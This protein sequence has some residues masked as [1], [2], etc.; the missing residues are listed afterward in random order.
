MTT[1]DEP[2]LRNTAAP[3]PAKPA[4]DLRMGEAGERKLMDVKTLKVRANPRKSYS[5]ESIEELAR[6]IAEVGQIQD[7]LV[8]LDTDGVPELIV[9]SRRKR[10]IEW[11]SEKYPN[12]PEFSKIA[13]VVRK[14]PEEAIPAIQFIENEDR[15]ALTAVEVAD[16]IMVLKTTLGW[17]DDTIAEKL[18][19]GQKKIVS[20]YL[21]IA[22]APPWLKLYAVPSEHE[23]TKLD[24]QGQPVRNADGKKQ[25]TTV[26]GVALGMTHLFELA[27]FH[28][29]IEKWDKKSKSANA[30]HV[31]QAHTATARNAKKAALEDWSKA[32][33]KA[34]LDSERAK[35]T[36]VAT[37]E[38]PGAPEKAP[39]LTVGETRINID[40]SKL[41]EP[42][43]KSKLTE[44]KP[45]LVS[46]LTKL[47]FKNVILSEG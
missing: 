17:S 18:G 30:D 21:A 9:G 34:S 12:R 15:E 25:T 46:V 19:W 2:T 28:R 5:T 44:M 41:T 40:V 16:H 10:A 27:R 6:S 7:A 29:D 37:P 20:F 1:S 38:E 33:L 42:L 3:T 39:L 45:G 35:L 23:V 47:G 22:E 43:S 11:L 8:R 31:S 4:G 14:I 13:V 32:K 36:G 26:K 24:K